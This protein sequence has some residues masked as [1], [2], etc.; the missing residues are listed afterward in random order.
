MPD[1]EKP[2]IDQ[3]KKAARGA[4]ADMSKEEFGPR[5]RRAGEAKAACTATGGGF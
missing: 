1:D 3:F 4:G 2:Q 5:H